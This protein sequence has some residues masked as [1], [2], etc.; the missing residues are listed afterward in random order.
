M[1]QIS[2]LENN[3]LIDAFSEPLIGFAK[4]YENMVILNNDS[5]RDAGTAHFSRFFDNRYFNFGLQEANMVSCAAGFA[6]RGKLP[7][8]IGYSS[9]IIANAWKQIKTDICYSNL[10]VKIIG[11]CSGIS[12]GQ[13][14]AG[15]H[16][17]E[18]I[19]MLRA[20]PNLKI[21]SPADF[22]EAKAVFEYMLEDFGPTYIRLFEGPAEAVYRNNC[23]FAPGKPDIMTEGKDM[24]LYAFGRMV[25]PALKIAD[26]LKNELSLR[27][28]NVSSLKPV[29]KEDLLKTAEGI[30]K[31]LVLE[32]HNVYG[33]LG[34]ILSEIFSE[35]GGKNIR[36]I[37][38]KDHFSESGRLNELDKKY[39]LDESSVMEEVLNFFKR[40][41][42]PVKNRLH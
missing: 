21:F 16:M 7:V 40:Q 33:G 6:I 25:F 37:G 18:D 3:N 19:S 41:D 10:N 11:L 29:D 35:H 5:T 12:G 24:V 15:M 31:C 8:I 17:A 2:G 27:V 36:K 39:G 30:D 23:T 1:M 38:I 28:V 4:K 26:E 13:D 42:Y 34:S 9:N 20:L 32:D 14:G 22:N